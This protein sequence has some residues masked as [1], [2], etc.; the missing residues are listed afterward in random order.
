LTAFFQPSVKRA[1]QSSHDAAP[2]KLR[3]TA[4]PKVPNKAIKQD[5]TREK[6]EGDGNS[7]GSE[8]S[9]H[10]EILQRAFGVSRGRLESDKK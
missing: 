4:V 1:S 6:F 5:M 8:D 2:K 10:D 7:Q 3:V 9:D